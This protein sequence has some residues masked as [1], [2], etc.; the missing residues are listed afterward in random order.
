V[1]T[2]VNVVGKVI[3][4]ATRTFYIE[5]KI[6]SD[7]N[8]KPNQI[9]M[10]KIR[11]YAKQN[12]VTIPMNALQN[13]EQG[14]FVMVASNE[15]GKMIARR[16]AVVV[17]ELYNDQLEVKSGIQQGDVLITEGFQGLYDGQLISTQAG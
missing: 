6:P 2:K 5:A 11:D 12:A 17:G 9:A 15:N 7:P 13:D 8:F 3:D 4:P 16:R 10:V 1:T 14:K